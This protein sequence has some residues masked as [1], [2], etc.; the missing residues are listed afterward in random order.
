M[1][2]E[3]DLNQVSEE[4]LDDLIDNFIE[5][6]SHQTAEMSASTFLELLFE[7]E[8][9]QV[10]ETIPL[11]LNIKDGVVEFSLP[12]DREATIQTRNNQI[13]VGDTL[14]VVTLGNQN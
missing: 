8:R 6:S 12:Q 2:L 7:T 3:K 9:K 10:Q 5:R 14:L 4:E 13:L 11:T 1:L